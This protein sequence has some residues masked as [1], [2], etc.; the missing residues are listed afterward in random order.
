MR[1]SDSCDCVHPQKFAAMLTIHISSN[2]LH[3]VKLKTY[4]DIC[5]LSIFP[6]SSCPPQWRAAILCA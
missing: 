3:N 5:I 2:N 6:S 4:N 1:Y